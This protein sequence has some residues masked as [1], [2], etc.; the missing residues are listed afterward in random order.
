MGAQ[1]L[2]RP[3]TSLFAGGKYANE[4]LPLVAHTATRASSAAQ[5]RQRL[6]A[7]LGAPTTADAQQLVDLLAK[8]LVYDPRARLSAHDALC[9]PF[10]APVF[11]FRAVLA[12][13][14]PAERHLG[15][16]GAAG[17]DTSASGHACKGAKTEAKA[18]VF[19]SSSSAADAAP[20]R[21]ASP[22]PSSTV[23]G[24]EAAGSDSGGGAHGKVGGS[25]GSGTGRAPKRK[26]VA[27]SSSGVGGVGFVAGAGQEF[28]PR[29]SSRP[30]PAPGTM[31]DYPSKPTNK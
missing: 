31:A 21:S 8:L 6:S 29:A 5:G 4:L 18:E 30:R 11:P 19:A 12:R 13:A 1:L 10:L 7:A 28:T 14:P 2:G 20:S 25:G 27:G 24:G 26:L 17:A 16:H 15:G 3:P 22:T 9:H 23:A